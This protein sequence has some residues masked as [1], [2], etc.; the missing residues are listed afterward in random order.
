MQRVALDMAKKHHEKKSHEILWPEEKWN[1]FCLPDEETSSTEPLST[2]ERTALE[3]AYNAL[4]ER[5]KDI[6]TEYYIRKPIL[7]SQR[8][9]KGIYNEI[10]D[11]VNTSGENVKQVI[12]RFIKAVKE[13]L[14]PQ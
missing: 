12:K 8:S 4:K 6:I 2:P 10:G 14:L 5:D 13:R 9:S 7:Q 11:M 3:G 1:D